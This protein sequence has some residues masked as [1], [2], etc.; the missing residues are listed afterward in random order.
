MACMEEPTVL[1]RGGEKTWKKNAALIMLAEIPVWFGLVM[2]REAYRKVVPGIQARFLRSQLKLKAL[3]T[4][5]VI[6]QLNPSD[7]DPLVRA[8]RPSQA[9]KLQVVS[10][11]PI[12]MARFI[13]MV[14]RA[15]RAVA[16]P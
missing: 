12:A 8:C 7:L 16:H 11:M 15:C 14:K 1:L 5:R 3:L 10:R 6:G 4:Y 9:R 2:E 13:L